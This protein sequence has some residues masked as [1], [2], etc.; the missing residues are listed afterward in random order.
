MKAGAVDQLR[1][2]NLA[3]L[4]GRLL[5]AAHVNAAYDRVQVQPRR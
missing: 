5:R 3:D 1:N 2:E 4:E